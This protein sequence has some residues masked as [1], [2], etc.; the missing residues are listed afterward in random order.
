MTRFRFLITEMTFS[1]GHSDNICYESRSKRKL[2]KSSDFE[3]VFYHWKG[4]GAL[5][6]AEAA[7][8]RW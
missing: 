8:N 2:I 7:D 4:D 5:L 1:K 6:V 3:R